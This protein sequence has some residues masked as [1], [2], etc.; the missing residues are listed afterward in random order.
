MPSSA[1]YDA[2]NVSRL[3]PVA[4]LFV[5]S[6]GGLSHAFEEDTD[7]AGVAVLARA[8]EYWPNSRSHHPEK[9]NL[10]HRSS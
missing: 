1:L 4:L 3:V 6:I 5:P 2:T 8:A 9:Y 10:R 7:E